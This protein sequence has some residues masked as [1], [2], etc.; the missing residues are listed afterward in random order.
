MLKRVPVVANY[1][2]K[3]PKSETSDSGARGYYMLIEVMP[4]L[5]RHPMGKVCNMVVNLSCEI[6][7]QVQDDLLFFILLRHYM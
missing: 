1:R 5:F 7:K 3:R 6:L 4:N 2:H